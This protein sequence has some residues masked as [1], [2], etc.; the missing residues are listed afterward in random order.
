VNARLWI[1]S[2]VVVD[3]MHLEKSRAERWA[4]RLHQRF[5]THEAWEEAKR[6]TLGG[7]LRAEFIHQPGQMPMTTDWWVAL[8]VEDEPDDRIAVDDEGGEWS[9]LRDGDRAL[10]SDEALEWLQSLA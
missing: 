3:E 5:P 4:E 7:Q 2:S 1:D 10:R 8:L 9:A 6:S